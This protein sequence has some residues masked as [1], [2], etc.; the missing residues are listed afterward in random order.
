[1]KPPFFGMYRAKV[2]NNKDREKFGRVMVWIPDIMPEIEDSKG[3]WARPA[4]NPL[5]GRNQENDS[6]HHYMGSSYIPKKGSWVWIFFEKGNPNRP[7]YFGALDLENTKVLPENQVGTNYEDKW[8]I[9]KSHDG[10]TITI[11]DD[12][13]DKRVEITGRKK[14]LSNPPTGDTNSV[15]TIDGNQTTILL[16]ERSGKEKVLI[17]THKGDFFHIDVDEQKL[18][19]YFKGDI[20]IKT[21]SKLFITSI[22]DMHINTEKKLFIHSLDDTNIKS[23]KKIFK[24]AIDDINIKSGKNIN[25]DAAKDINNKSGGDIKRE[26]VGDF[27]DKSLNNHHIDATN[28]IHILSG[29]DINIDGLNKLNEQSGNSQ[30]GVSADSASPAVNAIAATPEGN[31][32]T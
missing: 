15:Y 10:R 1:M 12:P 22:D 11:S 2:I 19:A 13:D 21:D 18:Q 17:R 25:E 9:F 8:T 20:H 4:N 23:D 28:D 24:E 32:D 7:Y 30:P 27:S 6:E 5:G 31:R 26:C 16:D 3:L 14:Q 29:N